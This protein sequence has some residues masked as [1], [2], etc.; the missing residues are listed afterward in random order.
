MEFGSLTDQRPVGVHVVQPWV[1]EEFPIQ[2]EDFRCELVALELERTFW[3]K[4]TILHAEFHRDRAKP[5]R[6]RFSR[7]YSDMAAL[8]RHAIAE[9]ALAQED[10]RQRVADWKSRFFAAS[11]SRYDLAKP[12][13]FRLAPPEFRLAELKRDYQGMRDMFI[14]PP[15]SFESVIKTVSDLERQ[16]NGRSPS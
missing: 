3:E 1:A 13:T 5:I 6:D 2:L 11:W 10:L 14:A 9:R 4:A 12:G 16:I 7:H 8:A 15:P